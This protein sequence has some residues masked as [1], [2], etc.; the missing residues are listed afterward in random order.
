ML[1]NLCTPS[2]VLTR[3]FHC[4]RT[5]SKVRAG[6]YRV[7]LDR[8]RP[9]TYEMA[10]NPDK[11]GTEKSFNSFNTGQL[12]DTYGL[13]KSRQIGA[14]P[15]SHKLFMEDLFIRKFLKGTWSEMFLSEIIVKRQHNTVR[16]SGLILKKIQTR[17]IYFLL[18][19]TEEMLSLWLKCPVKLELQVVE[20][21][22]D[23]IYKYI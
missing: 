14:A 18:G 7:T 12:E 21:P 11:I 10:L 17:K 2:L 15:L 8:S 19:Y 1:R 16:V 9:L 13:A 6:R 22:K 4:S 20:D 23:V 5:L 3:S